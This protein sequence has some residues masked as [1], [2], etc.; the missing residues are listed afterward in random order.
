ML[1]ED[2]FV[3]G[4][5]RAVELYS[6]KAPVYYYSFGHEGSLYGVNDRSMPGEVKNKFKSE[7]S[8]LNSNTVALSTM[9][10]RNLFT[11]II[12]V[13]TWTYFKLIPQYP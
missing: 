8:C 4:I 3:R 13:S 11:A 6:K 12:I 1:S 2:Q 10:Y 5:Y 7:L 9:L